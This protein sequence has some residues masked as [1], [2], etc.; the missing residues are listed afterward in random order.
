MTP[1][2]SDTPKTIA[3][4]AAPLSEAGFDLSVVD[5]LLATTRAVRRRLDYDRPVERE[6]VLD[7]IRLSQQAPTG[8]NAQH[9]R[10]LVVDD[11]TKRKAIGELYARGIPMLDESARNASDEQTAA[12]YKH[13]RNFASRLGDV[14][15]HVF[16]C[17][18]GRLADDAQL[19]HTT[20]YFGSIYQAVWSFQ[21]ALRSRGLGSVFT[22]MHLA[23]EEESRA[24]LGLP[25]NVVQTALLPVAYTVGTNF[26]AAKRPGP[27][28][29][30]H[31]NE[32][33]T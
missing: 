2:D 12:V 17:L 20:T 16:P 19:V 27:E 10:W 15:V 18:E 1:T 8:T 29:I 5:R 9:W 7:C 30:T 22:T 4:N 23:F 6:V 13:A 33:G 26:K 31:F 11:P 3:D 32:W 28:T 24:I 25:D 21:L 14:P